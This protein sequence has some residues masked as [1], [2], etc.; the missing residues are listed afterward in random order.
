M[1]MFRRTYA[2]INLDHLKH[3]IQT[4]QKVFPNRFL[5]PMLKA[6]AYGHGDI[7]L[8]LFLESIGVEHMGVCL[9]EEGLLLRQSGVRAEILVFRGFD[10]E[11]AEKIIQYA[12]TPVVSTWDQIDH[13]E[14][15]AANVPVSVHL[16][17]DTGMNRLGFNLSEATQVYQRLVQ[18][19]NIRVKA[20]VTHLYQGEDALNEQGH[21]AQQ[22]RGLHGALEI[23]KSMNVFAHAL[24]SAGIVNLTKMIQDNAY[25]AGH[26]L[27]LTDW[28]LRPG[29]MIYG[30]NPL[31]EE[32]AMDLKPVMNLK[33]LVGT[34]RKLKK[35]DTVSYSARW[36]AERD[37]VIGV[38][39]I[40]YADGYHRILSNQAHVLFAG[41][42]VP[43]VGSVCMD[44]LMIDVTDVVK[45]QDLSRFKEQEVILFGGDGRGHFLSAEE[46]AKMAR[47]ITWEILTSVGERV[48]RVFVGNQAQFMSERTGG[49]L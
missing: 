41:H 28:G 29:L 48:P 43:V 40:G 34:Y 22:L 21:S 27:L 49:R 31:E 36:K 38:V 18:S 1:E 8:A 23:F 4:I 16:K 2:E 35:G 32:I 44:Y 24:N 42:R 14:A 5:C 12:M 30:Y 39:P 11:G 33:S 45:D 7:Q 9:I 17:F 13:L 6:N 47:T 20:L 26:P 25:A 3:N 15:V 46:L 19:K 37:S 10:R